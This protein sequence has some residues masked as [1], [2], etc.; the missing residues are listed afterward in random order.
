MKA[1]RFMRFGT[2]NRAVIEGF[3]AGLRFAKAIGPEVIY[4][5]IHVLAKDVYARARELPYVEMLSP[6]DD[7][8][9]GSLVSFKIKLPEDRLARL[10]QLCDERLIW[11]TSNPRLRVSTH[12][13][14]RRS[15]LDLFFETLAE[16]A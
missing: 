6:E 8:M 16:V 3:V 11:T 15:D 7:S 4:E 10:W 1:A 12:I 9:Y 13:H 14:T 5:R 2:N